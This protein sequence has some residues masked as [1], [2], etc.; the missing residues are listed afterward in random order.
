MAPFPVS[1]G[2]SPLN[3]AVAAKP[4]EVHTTAVV[5]PRAKI[6]SGCYIGPYCVIGD[7]VELQDDVRLESHCA[8]DG[9]TTIGAGTHIFPFA[10][11]GF[12]P[13]D[14]KYGGEPSQTRIGKRNVIREFV[15]VHRGTV[16]GGMLTQTG[17]DCL[18]MAQVHVA[19]DCI[20]GDNVIMA[21]AAT[22]AGHVTIEDNANVGAYSGVHQFCRVG[23]EAYIGG[24]SVVVKDALPFALSVGNHARCY[25][26]NITGMK[27][28]GYSKET[29][30]ALHRAYHLLL[31]SKLNTSQAVAKIREEISE[32]AEVETL[33][34]FIETSKRGVIK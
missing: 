16:G 4:N 6:G 15:T 5:S 29:I 30:S 32:S 9:Q 22:L 12:A 31:A 10:S 3:M 2:L 24:Y 25:G 19:H 11:I 7:D 27:R 23:R 13:Q 34:E 20:I 8:I 33:L 14:L 28:R 17:D 18:L 1:P 26:L 21:N